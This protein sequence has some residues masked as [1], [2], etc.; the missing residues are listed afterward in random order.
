MVKPINWGGLL[1]PYL[2]PLKER[3]GILPL[4]QY[5]DGSVRL[6]WPGLL[7]DPV[8]HGMRSAE[9]PIPPVDD[10]AAWAA[11][12]RDFFDAAGLAT[13]GALGANM[14]GSMVDNALGSA[15]G[16]LTP[17]KIAPKAEHQPG[18]SRQ[19][20][21]QV[22]GPN[23][24]IFM[25]QQYRTAEAGGDLSTMYDIL[26]AKLSKASD[27]APEMRTAME[28]EL[29]KLYDE[30]GP[31]GRAAAGI[32]SNA[33]PGAAVPLA[34]DA[35]ESQ[36]PQGWQR[37][38]EIDRSA[39]DELA[40][41]LEAWVGGP[42]DAIEKGY[43]G[44][45]MMPQALESMDD[46]T[47]NAFAA[48]VRDVLRETFGDKVTAYRGERPGGAQ[49]TGRQ[50]KLASY[51][52]D[53]RVAERFAGAQGLAEMPIISD[54]ELAAFQRTLDETGEV[55][56]GPYTYRQNGDY[57]DIYNRDGFVTDTKSIADEVRGM[58]E[59]ATEANT[60]RANAMANVREVS[61]PVDDIMWATDRFG[62]K[63]LIAR[64]KYSNAP[65]GA[66]IPLG[67]EGQEQDPQTL[68][69]A[70]ILKMIRGQK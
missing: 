9:T 29:K 8:Q 41:A 66:A 40:R 63:E 32:Y 23:W 65:T 43:A 19:A 17:Y 21:E 53:R 42:A 38:A 5:E 36:A 59:R 51:T 10:D 37:I 7:A 20:I 64:N 34:I 3:L 62:Q 11:K 68:T 39:P 31:V 52:T 54:A 33:K 15:G 1:E 58:N 46:A 47:L 16:K 55:K 35:A 18:A 4:G 12:S 6:A 24:D 57:V 50:N 13:T 49:T 44:G 14:A 2:Q 56:I 30:M 61:I 45:I 22:W 25:G 69:T 48:P 60:E 27:V 28:A 70:N 26:S 67:M